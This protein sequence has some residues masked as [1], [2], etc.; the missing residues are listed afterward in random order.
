MRC[1]LS[2]S[3]RRCRHF[4]TPLYVLLYSQGKRMADE[5]TANYYMQD[6]FWWAFLS[7]G[8][9]GYLSRERCLIV[10]FDSWLTRVL[11]AIRHVYH[12]GYSHPAPLS[13]SDSKKGLSLVLFQIHKPENTSH[14]IILSPILSWSV[15]CSS[16]TLL[17][18]LIICDM[19]IT[20]VS[21]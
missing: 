6:H 1:A 19:A 4:T 2:A 13:A 11:Q 15:V 18:S 5:S 14:F 3:G 12:Q 17:H 10:T 9:T 16:N 8:D 21:F 7:E 20:Q